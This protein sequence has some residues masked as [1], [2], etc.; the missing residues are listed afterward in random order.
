MRGWRAKPLHRPI[1]PLLRTHRLLSGELQV[2]Y[3]KEQG[4]TIC[5]YGCL[6]NTPGSHPHQGNFSD[7]CDAVACVDVCHRTALELGDLRRRPG[8]AI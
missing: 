3:I 8:V 5:I 6:N 2:T 4:I 1:G 7:I